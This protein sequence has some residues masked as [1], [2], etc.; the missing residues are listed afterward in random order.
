MGR[1]GR[2]GGSYFDA[3]DAATL[4]AGLQQALKHPFE[5]LD[6]KGVVVASGIVG[7]SPVSV[8]EGDYQI[9]VLSDPIREI[10]DIEVLSGIATLRSIK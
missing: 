10:N 4:K 6:D 7:G 9:R 1:A 2:G 3:P 8:P 5:V